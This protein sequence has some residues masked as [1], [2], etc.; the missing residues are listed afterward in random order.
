MPKFTRKEFLTRLSLGIAALG[1]PGLARANS[2]SATGQKEKKSMRPKEIQVEW[3][4]HGSFKFV[5]KTGKVILLDPWISTNPK[6]PGRYR[7]FNGFE[8]VD[9]ILFTHA[10]VDHF[11]LPDVKKLVAKYEPDIISPWEMS[12]FIKSEI[13]QAKC[14]TF[15]LSNIGAAFNYHGI[16][17]S[18][19]KAVHS[20]GAQ[21]TGFTGINKYM[22]RPVGYVLEFEN[23]M[24]IYHS[25][26]TA[27][28]SD[29]KLIIGDY[30]QPDIAILPIGNVFT[31]GPREAAHACKMIRPALVIPEHYGTFPALEPN[32]DNFIAHLKKVHPDTRALVLAPGESVQV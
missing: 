16:N 17:I 20:S 13:P 23:G 5:S 1:L 21:L 18:M 12:F 4:G 29:M 26:D 14:M 28:M 11:M 22:G 19:V 8:K 25:G 6:V 31:M 3:L 24:T 9:L 30:Y 32:A 2:S 10:H 7:S 15:Q 27:L